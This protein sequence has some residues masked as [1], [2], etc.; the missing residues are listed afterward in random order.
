[1]TLTISHCC[2][3]GTCSSHPLCYVLV[4]EYFTQY[5]DAARE[6]RCQLRTARGG[7]K[8]VKKHSEVSF[9]SSSASR[10]QPP[11]ISP[12]TVALNQRS[13]FCGCRPEMLNFPEQLKCAHKRHEPSIL[14]NAIAFRTNMC[15]LRWHCDRFLIESS[16]NT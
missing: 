5:F 14:G 3:W 9:T 7:E 11:S 1:M 15:I 12:S 8:L 16:H 13:R 10:S 4:F 6:V 2:C